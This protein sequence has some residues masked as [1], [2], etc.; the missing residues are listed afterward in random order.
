MPTV[1]KKLDQMAIGLGM[2]RS[3]VITF[4][5]QTFSAFEENK[6][7]ENMMMKILKDVTKK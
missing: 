6:P 3:G 7:L 4:L 2:S 1:V 5:T